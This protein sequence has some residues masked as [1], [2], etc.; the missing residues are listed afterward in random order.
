MGGLTK[1]HA[2]IVLGVAALGVL[3][4]SAGVI[5]KADSVAEN[6]SAL[7][8]SPA[9]N[10]KIAALDLQ[11][12]ETSLKRFTS[13]SQ[14]TTD[15]TGSSLFVAKAHF[16]DPIAHRPRRPEDGKGMVHPPVPD[17]WLLSHKLNLLSGSVLAEDPDKDGFTNLEEYLGESAKT[18]EEGQAVVGSTDPNDSKSHPPYRTK[19]FLKQFVT[20]A[21]LSLFKAYNGDPTK[22]ADLDFQINSYEKGAQASAAKVGTQFLK[23]GAI[24]GATPYRIEKFELKT[25]VNP[26][27]GGED[28]VSELTLKNTETEEPVVLV[29][30]KTTE[31]PD[32]FAVLTF[33]MGSPAKE[34]RIQRMKDFSLPGTDE[35]YK[36]IDITR[37]NAVIR[38][39]SGEEYSVPH[40]PK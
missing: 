25:K 14:W 9:K 30:N 16:I 7:N 13:P 20:R 4:V 39:A 40:L 23:L 21:F 31:S 5:F 6:F 10:D 17:K 29:L 3:G 38:R 32:S 1:K 36:L 18:P 24:V 22:P 12:I 2:I 34:M 26:K 35:S 19:L 11:P 28:D 8:N 37:D 27:T 15:E 33:L